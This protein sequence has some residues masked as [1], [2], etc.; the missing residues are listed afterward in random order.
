MAQKRNDKE[1]YGLTIDNF[2]KNNYILQTSNSNFY[3]HKDLSLDTPI[4]RYIPIEFLIEML[5]TSKM[6]ISNR[7]H[8]NDKREQGIKE[9]M[10]YMFHLSPV[11][12]S[13][14]K[15][16]D[17]ANCISNLHRDAYS[18]CVSCW[19]MRIDENI[20]QWNCYG[21]NTCRISTTIHKLIDSIKNIEKAVIIAP[22]HYTH[23]ERTELIEENI[24][25]KHIAYKDEQEIR[26]CVLCDEHHVLFDIKPDV[27]ISEITVN[28]FFNKSYRSFLKETM[29]TKFPYL[30]DKIKFSHLLEYK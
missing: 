9:D 26:L 21:H 15:T 25:N 14:K 23:I 2:H 24:F 18:S 19:T 4:C 13:K 28:P 12:R 1:T 16:L 20:M 29:E 11:Y 17:E 5:S 6:Y 30:N 22:I 3:L 10:K 27:L 7:Q 8:L